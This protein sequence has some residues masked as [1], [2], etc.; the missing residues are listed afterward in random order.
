[1][2]RFNIFNNIHSDAS[3][4]TNRPG[5]WWIKMEGQLRLAYKHPVSTMGTSNLSG[6]IIDYDEN[7]YI[8]YK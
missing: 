1:M 3:I 5:A 4:D 8:R 6:E 7:N 2:K